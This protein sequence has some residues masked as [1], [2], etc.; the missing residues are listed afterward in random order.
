M[1][2]QMED[3]LALAMK[4]IEKRFVF[5]V[6][7]LL[8]LGWR[9][10]ATC[11]ELFDVQRTHSGQTVVTDGLGR[12]IILIPRGEKPLDDAGHTCVIET[13]V[14]R[15]TAST[16]F[17]TA[18][19]RALDVLDEVL[20]GL[21]KRKSQW[22]TP[23]IQKGIDSGHITMLGQAEAIDYEQLVLLHPDVALV[24]PAADFGQ[25]EALGIPV[26]VTYP[27]SAM[28]LSMRLRFIQFL[29]PFFCKEDAANRFLKSVQHA[30]DV[31]RHRT[32]NIN[33]KPMA[34]W[35]DFYGRKSV[36]EPGNSWMAQFMELAGGH[37]LFKDVRGSSTQLVSRER[38]YADGS[39]ADVILTISSYLNGVQT[40]SDLKKRHPVW[41]EIIPAGQGRIF[42]PLPIYHESADQLSAI[43]MEIAA[44]LH[45]DLFPEIK[46]RYFR[47]LL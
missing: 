7:L 42:C 38:V 40:K 34:M 46:L 35:G 37:Y 4:K 15:L 44:M 27:Q 5:L 22:L 11:A 17:D 32:R 1:A 36:V 12:R 9:I 13:P 6:F 33:R 21:V 8:I 16:V 41:A 25:F 28:D 39:R 45:P 10:P 18:M 19:L 14:Q 30:I 47:K 26:V 31:I 3:R 43:L 24:T 2:A 29:A 23:E 20:V